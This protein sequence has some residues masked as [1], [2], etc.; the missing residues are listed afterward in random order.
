MTLSFPQQAL[1]NRHS[2]SKEDPMDLVH[3]R[4]AGLDISKKDVK[5]CIRAPGK[6][7]GTFTST[8]TTWGSTTAQVLALRDFLLEQHVGTV[9]MEATSDYWKPFYYVFEDSLPVMLVNA[10][11]ARNIPGRKTDVSDAAW[12]AQLGAHGLLR[13]SFVP[14]PPIRE[15]RDLTRARSSV[16]HERT[17]CIQRLE[18]FLESTGIKLSSTVSDLLG[19]SSRAMLEALVEGEHDPVVLAQLARGTLR[20]KTVALTEAL[21]GR[22]NEHHAFMVRLYLD[23]IDAR[24]RTIATLTE[25]IEEAMEPFRPA[26][27]FLTTIP[28]VSNTAADVIIAETGA[29]MSVFETPGRLASWAGVCPGSNESAGRVKSTKARPGNKNLK[30][31]LGTAAMS[32]SRSKGTYLSARYKRL[33]TR[34]GKPKTIVAIEHAI[35]DAVWHMLAQGVC[36][37]DP[38]PEAYTRQ[39]PDRVRNQAVKQLNELGYQVTLEPASA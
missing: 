26:R 18:K 9:L 29:D 24:E 13:A 36:Y 25:R 37:Q 22:F 31:A 2:L 20:N 11:A 35:L 8:V 3:E 4:A 28:G 1:K 15:L 6:R 14:P 30:A 27:D 19:V 5:V 39:N 17:R 23:E 32:I 34:R 16:V 38:G 12:L 21:V 33:V 7:P 10:K